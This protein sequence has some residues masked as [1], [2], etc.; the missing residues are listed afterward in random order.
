MDRK[1]VI[2]DVYKLAF[3]E[4]V[5]Y[6][7]DSELVSDLLGE[8]SGGDKPNLLRLIKQGMRVVDSITSHPTNHYTREFIQIIQELVGRVK[9]GDQVNIQLGADQI[10]TT[11]MRYRNRVSPYDE[12]IISLESIGPSIFQ[13][14]TK[15]QMQL[16][17]FYA[18]ESKTNMS[19]K[20]NR[21]KPSFFLKGWEL[22]DRDGNP[23]VTAAESYLFA[24]EKKIFAIK[25]YQTQLGE[26]VGDFSNLPVSSQLSA[27]Q[28]RFAQRL[29]LS[30]RELID[31]KNAIE[32]GEDIS[33]ILQLSSNTEQAVKSKSEFLDELLE[34]RKS[35]DPYYHPKIDPLIISAEIFGF[36]FSSGEV[37][38]NTGKHKEAFNHL[39]QFQSQDQKYEDLNRGEKLNLLSQII[40]NAQIDSA[41]LADWKSLSGDEYRTT[42]D[43]LNSILCI[44]KLQADISHKA[45]HTHDAELNSLE[46]VA[47]AKIAGIDFD[48]LNLDI[49]PLFETPK[50]L[51][52]ASF[53]NSIKNMLRNSHMRELIKKREYA[54]IMLGFSD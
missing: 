1:N 12:A 8:A 20:E 26:I 10:A 27:I 24:L 33:T 4:D 14:Y 16:N 7:K 46:L 23:Y 25:Q 35:L 51:E 52:V 49:V 18:K 13:A 11:P 40:D 6:R 15:L 38:Q 29:F 47:L 2:S 37:R 21:P 17:D 45:C 50:D 54:E 43:I 22:Y 30:E 32:T 44:Q 48:K 39:I 28:V 41:T 42:K 9:A 53:R 31:V 5:R 36:Y 34:V 3:F 19:I